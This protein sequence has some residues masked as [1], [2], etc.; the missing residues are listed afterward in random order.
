MLAIAGV[1]A[2][3]AAIKTW[4]G[5]GANTNWTTLANWSGDTAPANTDDLIFGSAFTSGTTI[6]LAGGNRQA[7]TITFDTTT[8]F[9]I[10]GANTLQ[11]N[12][13]SFTR[14]AASSGT[15][16][17]TASTLALRVNTG[18]AIDGSGEL[19]ISS[20]ISGNGLSLTKS[21]TGL[22]VLSGANTFS[23]GLIIN[24]GTVRGTTNAAALGAGTLTLG[25]GNLE[26]ANDT[27][28]NFGDATTVTASGTIFP[29]RLT[30]GTGV[31]HT[32]GTLAIGA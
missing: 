4:D 26:L 19:A 14:T 20:I 22:L 6:S 8:S 16:S 24:A 28:L 27:G 29:E 13:A 7:G 9:S 31:T 32:L 21:G 12:G 18:F 11:L 17:I 25:G 15:Q 10:T 1:G 2:S 30:S 23:G 5:G 3:E